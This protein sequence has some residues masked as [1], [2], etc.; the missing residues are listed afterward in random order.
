RARAS[1]LGLRA[2]AT[3]DEGHSDSRGQCLLQDGSGR[4]TQ[5]CDGAI[6]RSRHMVEVGR[7]DDALAAAAELLGEKLTTS[8]VELAHHVVEQHQRYPVTL[9]RQYRALA[10][11]QREEREALLAL[12]AVGAQLATVAQDRELI[13]VWTV[14]GEAPFQVA[15]ELRFEL[16]HELLHAGGLRAW[17]IL[18]TWLSF[19]SELNGSLREGLSEE[20]DG[21]SPVLAQCQCMASKL[22]I[23]TRK[24]GTRG[25][26]G[27][28]ARN[29]RIALGE[30][31]RIVVAG[32][33][34]RWPHGSDQPIEVSAA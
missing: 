17:A 34:P 19:Q 5:P 1:G 31:T 7:G 12:G 23:P 9:A 22:E 27:T 29:Q 10:Q 14:R 16:L 26:A 21:G 13:A 28:Q 32:R 4:Y 33:H 30:H 25:A 8:Q 11:K 2:P 6:A 3:V 24:R 18:E 20:R 15:G